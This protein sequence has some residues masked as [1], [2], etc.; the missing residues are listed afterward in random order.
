MIDLI[1]CLLYLFVKI[2]KIFTYIYK[3][4]YRVF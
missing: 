4:E 3:L 1:Q 2:Y